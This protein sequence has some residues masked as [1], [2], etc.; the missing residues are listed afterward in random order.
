MVA[1]TKRL[2]VGHT[3]ITWADDK[4]ED[5]VRTIAH[6]G[7]HG[8][9]VFSWVLGALKEKNALDLFR[10]N[11]IP[12]VSSYFSM[13][14]VDPAARE[15][16]MGKLAAWGGIVKELGGGFATL[17]GNGL[18][19]TKFLFKDHQRHITSTLNEMGRRLMD[20]GLRLVFHPHTGTPVETEAEIRA[21]LDGVDASCVG[22]APDVGQIQKGGADPARLVRDYVSM[23]GLVHLKDYCGT[24]EHD[25]DGNEKDS[26]GFCCYSPLGKGVV[27]L[28]G[29][30]DY[31]EHSRFNGFVMV[32]LDP[33]KAMPMSADRAVTVNRDYLAALGYR[34]EE[35]R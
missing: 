30:L 2:S 5:A 33:G 25:A 8:I 19:R 6:L 16:E 28:A 24:V 34:F 20:M 18:D 21:V 23:I 3:A 29:I 35:R 17:G 4:V 22:F 7:F 15:T 14:I 26:S 13:D 11:G 1:A 32:E 27:D 31:L 12:L 10:R 9:E